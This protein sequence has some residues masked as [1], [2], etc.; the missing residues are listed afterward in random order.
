MKNSLII[1]ATLISSL[2]L[3]GCAQNN[4]D[5]EAA[6]RQRNKTDITRVNYTSPHQV[7]PAISSADTTDPELD[8]NRNYNTNSNLRNNYTGNTQTTPSV[9]GL[10]A[11]KII[12]LAEV[13]DANVIVNDNNAYVAVKMERSSQGKLTS[14]L[15]NRI[16]KRIKSADRN[17]DNVYISANPDFYDQMNTYS[18]VIRNGKSTSGFLDAFSDTIRRVFP[19]AK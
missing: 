9:S 5:N 18:E 11:K 1:I 6:N 14:D 8:R 7:G 12:H 13:D 10:A 17:V 16:A 4:M 3:T 19:N 15:E 2:Y